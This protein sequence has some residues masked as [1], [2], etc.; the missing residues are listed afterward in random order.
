MQTHP[1][2]H[3]IHTHSHTCAHN[4]HTHT[5]TQ[6]SSLYNEGMQPVMYSEVDAKSRHLGW[7]RAGF[8]IRYFKTP[9]RRA[10][11]RQEAYYYGLTWSHTFQHTHDT[12]YFAHCY[13]YTYS[14]MQVL[15]HPLGQAGTCTCSSIFSLL[16]LARAIYSLLTP[17]SSLPLPPPP[18][19]PPL[20]ASSFTFPPPSPLPPPLPP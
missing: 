18:L 15:P 10:D 11:T 12:C 17:P 3:T 5:H 20:L 8:N 13:P 6:A 16:L 19:P 14:D 7:R 2:T 1:L 9:L 4:T